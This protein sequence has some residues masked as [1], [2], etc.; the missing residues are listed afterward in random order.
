MTADFYDV[1]LIDSQDREYGM[2]DD[3]AWYVDDT[4]NYKEINPSMSITG[5]MV[6]NVPSDA[7]DMY[8]LI[9]KADTNDYY[10][11]FIK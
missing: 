6:Y 10:K 3:A 1:K 7:S 4:I 11:F 9:G 5:S 2:Y 8:L